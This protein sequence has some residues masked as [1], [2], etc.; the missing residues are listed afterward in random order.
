MKNNAVFALIAAAGMLGGL[1]WFVTRGGTESSTTITPA[2][3]AKLFSD[4]DSKIND[5][6]SIEIKKGK[7]TLALAKSEGNSW[8][9]QSRA[10]Y[11]AEF[12]KVKGLV[13]GLSK[14]AIIEPKTSSPALYA[15]IGVEDPEKATGKD[16]A[17]PALITLKDSGGKTIA[18]VIVGNR[19]GAPG[20]PMEAPRGEQGTFVRRTGEAQSFLVKDLPPAD[21][22]ILSW[23]KTE[24]LRVE[25]ARMQSATI[26]SPGESAPKPPEGTQAGSPDAPP[27]FA[28]AGTEVVEMEKGPAGADYVLKNPPAGRETKPGALSSIATA[29]SYVAMDDVAKADTIFTGDLSQAVTADFKTSDGLHITAK[30]IDKDGKTWAMFAADCFPVL[31]TPKSEEAKDPAAPTPPTPPG[32]TPAPADA[33]K[34]EEKKAEESGPPVPTKDPKV[35]TEAEDLNKRLGGWAFAI[36]SFK[37]QQLKTRM[38]DVL[39]ELAAPAAPPMPGG[40][41]GMPPEGGAGTPPEVLN[42]RPVPPPK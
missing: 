15:K 29:L 39:K 38:K 35:V 9:L 16:D 32:P 10:G 4:L 28:A 34:P 26:T 33:S 24:I 42:P 40:Q 19:S 27:S 21:T 1:A 3:N 17:G 5:V 18:S 12:E 30:V 31:P 11:P 20:N 23:L 14:A 7:D 37:A 8:V 22:G 6:A 13:V 41:P 2:S 25:G 36:P